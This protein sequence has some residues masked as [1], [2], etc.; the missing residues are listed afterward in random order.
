MYGLSK[1]RKKLV[2]GFPPLRLILTALNK[3]AYI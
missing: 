3:P 2:G 1:A